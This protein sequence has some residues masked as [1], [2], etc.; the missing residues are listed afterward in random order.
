MSNVVNESNFVMDDP[1]P[2][3]VEMDLTTLEFAHSTQLPEDYRRFLLQ[4][5]GGTPRRA[6]I[7]LSEGI[8]AIRAFYSVGATSPMFDLSQRNVALRGIV[9]GNHLAIG[10]TQ[11][12]ALLVLALGPT[13][14]KHGAVFH[15]GIRPRHARKFRLRYLSP[16]F[17]TLLAKLVDS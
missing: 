9:P 2:L 4:W 13:N 11:S 12:Q 3:C 17:D 5:N 16:S 10:V 14:E 8:D 15:L 7:P 6:G 1:G